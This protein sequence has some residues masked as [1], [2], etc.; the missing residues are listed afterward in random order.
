MED[1]TSSR[2]YFIRAVYQW[3]TDNGLTPYILVDVGVDY[4]DVPREYVKDGRIILNVAPTAVRDLL[5]GNEAISFSARFAGV[6]RPIYAPIQ[7]VLAVYA[8]ENG[9]GIFFEQMGDLEPP[10]EQPEP[11]PLGPK[12]TSK[13]PALKVVK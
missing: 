12:S 1:L 2:P 8:R 3:I 6:A 7:S 5:L 4:T 10:P 13:K 11:P 9:K